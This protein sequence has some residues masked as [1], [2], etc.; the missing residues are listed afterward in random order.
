MKK[1][2]AVEAIALTK[3][4]PQQRGLSEVFS[5]KPPG[6]TTALNEVSLEIEEGEVYGLLGP[7]GSGKTT[8]LKLLSTILSPS[9]GTA[10]IFGL[11]IHQ[12]DRA[13]RNLVSLVTGEERSLYWRLTGRQ[14]L[15]F[16][17]RLYALDGVQVKHKTDELLELFDLKDAGRLRV[18]EYSTGMKQR[19]AVARGLLSGPKLLFLD[20]PTRGLD[21]IA[22]HSLLNGVKER[23]VDYF[24]NTVILTTHIMRE[25]EQLCK[26]IAVLNRGTLAYKG[27]VE[28]LRS[29]L[30]R[31]DRYSI[32]TARLTEECFQTLR[33]REG[34]ASC[35]RTEQGDGTTEIELQFVTAGLGLSDILKHFFSSNVEVLRCT[36]KEQSLEE[37]FRALFDKTAP[38]NTN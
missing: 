36:K 12:H 18:A 2:L 3:R 9:S 5:G 17:A 38:N 33:R 31:T 19:L 35:S 10:R 30:E 28:G 26:R 24:A 15:E 14:N 37:M 6:E 21:P 32:V 22:A 11:D 25:V 23:A 1:S 34:V 29:S 27:T 13:I 20:E 8:F 7:N 16:F 4:Y